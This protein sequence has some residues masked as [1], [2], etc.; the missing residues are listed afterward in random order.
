MDVGFGPA[1]MAHHRSIIRG[2]CQFYLI[3][4]GDK[5]SQRGPQSRVASPP[6]ANPTTHTITPSI[7]PL[8]FSTVPSVTITPAVSPII[9]TDAKGVPLQWTVF[10]PLPES[11]SKICPLLEGR[12]RALSR[13]C[14]HTPLF[15]SLI[16]LGAETFACC[17]NH[18]YKW[19]GLLIGWGGAAFSP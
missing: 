16:F 15:F 14:G 3:K 18:G 7:P 1:G 19:K 2:G 13:G 10:F 8:P 12:A 17:Q 6:Q 9:K 4:V 5:L 11:E